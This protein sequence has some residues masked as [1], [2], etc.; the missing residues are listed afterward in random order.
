MVPGGE[1]IKENRN[2]SFIVLSEISSERLDYKAELKSIG[3]KLN[4]PNGKWIYITYGE[5][6]LP[7]LWL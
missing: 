2:S 7:S 4:Q 6:L 1:G 5:L 3:F